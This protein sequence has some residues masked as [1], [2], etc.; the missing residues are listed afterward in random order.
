MGVLKDQPAKISL[1]GLIESAIIGKIVTTLMED[2]HT[3]SGIETQ[4][5]FI[6][7]QGFIDD[8]HHDVFYVRLTPGNDP[9]SFI[10]D[11]SLNLTAGKVSGKGILKPVFAF[12]EAWEA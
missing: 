6:F 7:I 10:S 8:N 9:D 11:W 3:I 1:K 2:G 12:A 4:G 5:H